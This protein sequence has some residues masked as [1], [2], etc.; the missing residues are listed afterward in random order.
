M[1][2]PALHESIWQTHRSHPGARFQ[3]SW[4]SESRRLTV[5][6][7]DAL[8]AFL[9]ESGFFTQIHNACMGFGCGMSVFSP[10]IYPGTDP[11]FL[12]TVTKDHLP[13]PEG[14]DGT[15]FDDGWEAFTPFTHT[16]ENVG[17]LEFHEMEAPR[18]KSD[19]EY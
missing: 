8:K 9:P 13:I 5:E 18:S 15:R 4:R 10:S 14:K 11:E 6:E 17:I 2:L 7:W 16:P 1:D 12:L 3:R 19:Y